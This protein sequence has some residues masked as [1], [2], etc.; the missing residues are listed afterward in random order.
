[1]LVLAV[2]VTCDPKEGLLIVGVR[3]ITLFR[4]LLLSCTV[5]RRVGVE[6]DGIGDWGRVGRSTMPA[7]DPNVG[8]WN[9]RGVEFPCAV[10]PPGVLVDDIVETGTV[11]GILNLNV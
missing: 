9:R 5:A 1:V 3:L 8:E 10:I 4:R 6:G 11:K 2:G 7:G